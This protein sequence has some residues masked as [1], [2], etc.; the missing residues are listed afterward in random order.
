MAV[1]DYDCIIVGAGPAGIFAALEIVTKSEGKK[2]LLVEKGKDLAGRDRKEIF[3][4]WGGAG[5]YS[6]GKLNISRDVGGFL[7][8]YKAPAELDELLAYADGLYLKYGAP[9]EIKGHDREAVVKLEEAAARAGLR[10]ISFP[11][12]HIGTDRCLGLLKNLRAEL[13]GKV[14]ML[15]DR[16]VAEVIT[17]NGAA[18]GIRTLDG[19]EFRSDF[20][21][22]CPGRIGARWL[23]EVARKNGLQTDNNPVDIGVRVEVPATVLSQVTDVVHEA[24]LTY[25]SRKFDDPVRTFCMNPYGV[26]VKERNAGFC[27]VNGH[28]YSVRKSENT[29]FAI[30]VSTV[31]TEPFREPIAYGE[32]IAKLANLLGGGII[33][34]RL[35]DLLHGRRSTADRIKRG[36]LKPTLQDATP[37]DLSFVLPYRYVSDIIEMLEALD[38]FAPGLNSPSTL[39]Y[40]VEVK[41]YSLRPRLTGALETEIKNLFAAG[42]GAGVTRGI[43]QASVS[44]VIAAREALKRM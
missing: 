4:G 7:N 8:E 16:E 13:E 18:A 36:A 33:V 34:Q 37:G 19:A 6:D 10:L 21:I 35:G 27:T 39:L 20:I 38:R 42:D 5:T 17:A 14:D 26:V 3:S 30:L 2:V 44:G 31:F 32:Y 41:F 12:R 9:A 29:N 43:L 1:T 15:F 40:G 25:N 24:K 11:I 22:L 28:S 23:Q